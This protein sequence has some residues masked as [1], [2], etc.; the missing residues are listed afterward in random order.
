MDRPSSAE[1][2]GIGSTQH[3]REERDW[4]AP[5]P[6]RGEGLDRP[7]TA[8]RTGIGS[9]QHRREERD[10]IAPAP[11][12]GQGS[13]RPSTAERRGIGS[14][15]HRRAERDWIAP[16]PQIGE[17]LDRPSTEDRRGIRPQS[18]EGWSG[19]DTADRSRI[20]WP[21][22]HRAQ[23]DWITPAPQSG[24]E[25]DRNGTAELREFGSPPSTA[26]LRGIRS[27]L[28]TAERR[29]QHVMNKYLFEIFIFNCCTCMI[30][31]L[32]SYALNI[33]ALFVLFCCLF[34]LN[35]K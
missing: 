7:G 13:D 15:Q 32:C 3:R 4:I 20:V 18:G 12:S 14:P 1:W 2:R 33:N 24:D 31:N 10:W 21:N 8:E 22:H 29:D 11:Q 6:Q 17:G 16:A 28:S 5:A 9:P 26:E 25:L 34:F 23:R 30:T 19:P 35:K 27:P